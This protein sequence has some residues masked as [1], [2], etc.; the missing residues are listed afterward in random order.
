L[1]TIALRRDPVGSHNVHCELRGLLQ[2]LTPKQF[3]N[4]RL[5][6]DVMPFQP[7]AD[8]AHTHTS[9]LS[10]PLSAKRQTLPNDL[11]LSPTV[12]DR[13]V[14]KPFQVLGELH[15]EGSSG[16]AALESK[17]G[18]RHAP[19]AIHLADDIAHGATCVVKENLVELLFPSQGFKG[20]DSYA[21]LMERAEQEA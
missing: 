14:N 10:Y 20:S 11:I 19:T 8:R 21:R 15:G 13:K 4:R 17:E 9:H 12:T 2:P 18:H 6:T 7:L 16:F 3:V 5:G 1:E